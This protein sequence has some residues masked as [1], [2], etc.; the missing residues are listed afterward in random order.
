MAKEFRTTIQ[1]IDAAPGQRILVL[2]DIHGHFNRLVQLLRK[3]EYGG[4]DIL[5]IVGDLIDKGPESL[6]VV[7]YV[8]ELCKRYPVY[9]SMG[10]VDLSRVQIILDDT[11]EA[12][13]KFAGFVKWENEYWGGG[14]LPEMLSE[15]GIGVTQ[16]KPD[17]ALEYMARIREQFREELEFLLSRPTILTAGQ[18][19]F[20]HGGV[21]TDD[22]SALEGTDAIPYLKNDNFLSQG[23]RFEKY[24][25]VTGHW[26]VCLYR[27]EY[28]DMSPLFDAKRRILCIDGG[29]GVKRQGQLNGIVLPDC[30]AGIEDITWTS[31]DDFPVVTA[32]EAEKEIPASIHLDYFDDR[33][34]LLEERGSMGLFRQ[35]STGKEFEAPLEWT[36][37]DEK[38]LH[39]SSYCDRVLSVRQ[40]EQL[41]V[42]FRIEGKR[43]VKRQ[44]QIGW[45]TGAVEPVETKLQ[46]M[47]GA[48]E[49]VHWRREREL[50]VYE[51]LNKLGIPYERI[52]HCEANTM[53]ACKAVD[54]ALDAVICKNLFLC[55]QQRTK[56][57][58]LMMPEGK[59]F[60]TKELSKQI[61]SSRL[62]FAEAVYMEEF[63][64]I[65][66][67][68]VSV[69]GL[70]N[71][72]ENRVQLLI[73][74]DVLKGE[75][76][77][78]HP[79]MNTSSIRLQLADLLEKF[80]PAVQH[81]P[82]FVELLGE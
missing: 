63:L 42:L 33:I 30:M 64:H 6:R 45:Y 55:N 65:T 68:S 9:V 15:L 26:P 43:Y 18:Y 49:D 35:L 80:L 81:E 74:Q 61:N 12:G 3:L 69:M 41:S 16:V 2:S 75:Q 4:D 59:K 34:A 50:T 19:L 21:P 70:M 73:D 14:L 67:G 58:L 32:L 48:P 17:N 23:Y 47:Q 13:E 52:D 60:K 36:W 8:M 46:L 76:F 5:V 57:Y 82:V 22:L 54:E 25:V 78:C 44:G 11:P 24:T 38:G 77:G 37:E 20:V 1:H 53:E 10:N 31:Y 51:I 56:F 29:C 27:K 72:T 39:Y 28:E 40:G 62:S 79:C 66:P 71:D 7:Q